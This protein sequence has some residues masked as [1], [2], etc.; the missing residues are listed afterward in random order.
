MG[1]QPGALHKVHDLEI[2]NDSTVSFHQCYFS[3]KP[4]TKEWK[5]QDGKLDLN[6]NVPDKKGS[7]NGT[8]LYIHKPHKIESGQIIRINGT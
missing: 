4:S 5:L 3:Y 8:W 7:S 1:K 6:S 2:E